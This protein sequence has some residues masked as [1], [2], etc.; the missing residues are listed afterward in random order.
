MLERGGWLVLECGD[1]QAG[2]LAQELA[3]LGYL[4]V[5]KTHDLAGRERIVEGRWE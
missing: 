2:A 3:E 4:D 1:G 5:M